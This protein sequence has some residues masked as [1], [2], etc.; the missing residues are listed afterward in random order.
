[1]TDPH[2]PPGRIKDIRVYRDAFIG[3]AILACTPFLIFGAVEVYGAWAATGLLVVWAL[4]LG[5]GT[6]WFMPHPRWVIGLGLVSML[7]WLAVV[8]LNR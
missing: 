7:C 8:L 1:M 2:L 3:M 6:R 5:L 4:L